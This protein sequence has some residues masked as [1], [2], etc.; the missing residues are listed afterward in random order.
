MK[1]TISEVFGF[2]APVNAM[3]TVRDDTSASPYIRARNPEYIFRKEILSDFLA[4]IAG[5][6]GDDPLY[7][8]GPTGT[9]KSTTV[10]QV[11]AVLMQ[12]LYV[13][14]CHE[15]MEASEFMGRF[16]V[17]DGNMKW[18]DGPL[19]Q[20]LKDPLGAWILLDEVDTCRPGSAMVLNGL[21]E[22]RSII[23]PETGELLNPRQNGA[24]I[25][26]AGNTTGLDDESGMY[27]GTNRQNL[28]LMGRFMMVKMGYP[29]PEDEE[30]IILGAAPGLPG[31]IVKAMVKVA[32]DVRGVYDSGDTEVV[33]CTRSLIRWA[34]LFSWFR[35][36][37][38][39]DPLY[40]SLDRALAFK[41]SPEASAGLHEM[42]QRVF[43]K[44]QINTKGGQK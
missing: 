7:L 10:E 25:I 40:Y 22:G 16:V 13:V 26:C 32:N 2:P 38:G 21:I 31:E 42:V 35:K 28:A 17:Q 41:V 15:A 5:A 4:W 27:A 34:R 44:T 20:G 39:V 19:V 33:F 8:T 24:K 9:G 43:G 14:S 36:K 29:Q 3:V 12:P 6:S 11:A 37:P 1:K 30:E 18:Q 23:V